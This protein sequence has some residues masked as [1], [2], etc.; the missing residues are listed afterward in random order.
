MRIEFDCK[1]DESNQDKHG[2]SL[3]LAESLD[4][5]RTLV[6]PDSRR[7]YG[8]LRQIGIGPIGPRLHVIVFTQRGEAIRV[9]S[10]RKANSREVALYE[11]ANQA[12]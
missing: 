9:I 7:E 4:W 8:E 6:R 11:K 12:D 2:V 5:D 3:S 1:K 10:L